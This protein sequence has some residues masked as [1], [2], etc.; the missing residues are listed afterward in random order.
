MATFNA[1][2]AVEELDYDFTKYSVDCRG[3]IPEPTSKQMQT[4]FKAIRA[5]AVSVQ[6]LKS[7]ALAAQAGE[8]SDEKVAEVLATM[9]DL[10]IETFQDSMKDAI[11]ALCSGS[12][13]RVDL[14]TLPFRV[15]QAFMQWVSGEFRPEG[16]AATTRR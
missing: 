4:Y 3:P 5:I 12:P 9:E 1:G 14:D 7:D 11:T 8:M 6:K 10:D 15:L 16:E 2:T 13:S